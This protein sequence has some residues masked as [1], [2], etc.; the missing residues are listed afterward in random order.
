MVVSQQSW[1]SLPPDMI[2]VIEE[3]VPELRQRA[4]DIGRRNT[5]DNLKV[6]VANGIEATIPAKEAWRPALQQAA[7]DV[8]LAGWAERAGPDG[9][10]SF[11]EYLAPIVGY[12]M[13]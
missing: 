12:S 10:T 1:Q 4:W 6:V 13:E 2:A 3:L 11:N 8:V 9:K 7:L 5:E